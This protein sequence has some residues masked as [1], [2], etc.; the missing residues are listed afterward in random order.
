[1]QAEH[2]E[3]LEFLRQH[4]PFTELDDK[5]LQRIAEHTDVTYYKAGTQILAFGE[6][7]TD[8]HVIRSGVVEVYRRSGE[9]YDRLTTGGYFGQFGLLRNNRIR[10]PA[11]AL[12][13]TL[14]YLIPEA[15]FTELFEEH[16]NFADQVEVEDRS[17]LRQA[18]ARQIDGNQLMSAEVDS[19]IQREPQLVTVST[20]V[21]DAAIRM[22]EAGVTC[23]LVVTESDQ[24]LAA[25]RLVGI[26]TDKDIRNRLVVPGLPYDTPIEDIMSGCIASVEHSQFVFEAMLMMLRYNV[27]HLP[28]MRHGIPIGVIALPDVIR[29]ESQ[30]SLFVVRNIFKAKTVEELAALQPEVKACFSRLVAEDANSRMIGTSMAVIGRSFKQR[31]LEMAEAELGPPPVPY[32]F[33]A[34]GSMARE[35]QLIVT[36]QDNAMILDNAY[37]P[38][39]H[40]AYFVALAKFV[41]DGLHACGYE[42]CRG[43]IMATNPKW[44]KTLKQWQQAFVD[45]I[46]NPVQEVLLN[47]FIFFDM[48]GVWGETQWASQLTGLVAE[49]AMHN[50]MF[51]ACMARGALGRTPPLGF[52]KGFVMESDGDHSR[53]IN[54][55]R[56]GTAPLAD[57]VRVH[58]LAIGSRAHNSFERL[59]DLI[60]A[61]YLPEGQGPDL[62]DALEMLAMVRIRHQAK[63]LE[64]GRVPDNS[65]EPDNLSDFERKTLKDAFQIVS[66]AQKSLRFRYQSVRAYG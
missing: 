33:L 65:I 66:N 16:E 18:V 19:L 52:F 57:L 63:D 41:C 1:M 14:V 61:D 11:R 26:V 27:H 37:N 32:C 59:Q 34:L 30:N 51:L 10:F 3:I 36:D 44:R 40:E 50:P 45:W 47:S 22:S 23:V 42:Y 49:K 60:A 15:M 17:R 4:Q 9:L 12:E 62:R 31:L 53:S 28:V 38:K 8:W 2:I 21:R 5:V 46:E 6:E 48:Q 20:P 24:P 55:K 13:D 54:M 29:Y 25:S 64:A 7:I 58:A 43:G 35:E 56:R 39:E